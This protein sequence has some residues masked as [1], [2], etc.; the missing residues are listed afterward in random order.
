MTCAL[1]LAAGAPVVVL[2][3]HEDQGLAVQ[4]LQL[5]ARGSVIKGLEAMEQLVH[6]VPSS[7]ADRRGTLF[8][9]VI[10]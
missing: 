2:S 9:S 5:G 3:G 1:E 6:M 10:P 8:E 4:R 7:T